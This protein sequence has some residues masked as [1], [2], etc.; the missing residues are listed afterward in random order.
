MLTEACTQC[1]F[2]E[3]LSESLSV[4]GPTQDTVYLAAMS[5][6]ASLGCDSVSDLSCL[7][8]S[9]G[10]KGAGQG[11]HRPLP[12][13]RFSD[14]FL[15]INL[16][17]WVRGRKCVGLRCLLNLSYQGCTLP[18][19]CH[20]DADFLSV[21][22]TL[23]CGKHILLF[24]SSAE[25]TLA[26]LHLAIMNNTVM[27]IG[28]EFCAEVCVLRYMAGRGLCVPTRTLCLV[29]L[30]TCQTVFPRGCTVTFSPITFKGSTY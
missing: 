15:Q 4:S 30:G 6:E 13:P 5:L 7:T 14:A 3:C 23:F 11:C 16:A 12:S 10:K 28:A 2:P 24:C 22:D 26:C 8:I 25:G 9:P 29:L 17:L 21:D 19:T 1:A 20:C 27:E 18:V